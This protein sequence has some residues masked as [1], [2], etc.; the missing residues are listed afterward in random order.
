[1]D[2]NMRTARNTRSEREADNISR[3]EIWLAISRRD[4]RQSGDFKRNSAVTSVSQA[5]KWMSDVSG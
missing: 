4:K 3:Q 1:M 5:G 2:G